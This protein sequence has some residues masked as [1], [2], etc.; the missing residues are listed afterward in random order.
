M[1]AFKVR[2]TRLQ[3]S[4]TL[5]KLFWTPPLPKA[6]PTKQFWMLPPLKPPLTLQFLTQPSPQP[7]NCSTELELE[8]TPLS[9]LEP[10]VRS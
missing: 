1:L 3:L 10:L 5:T 4:P 9:Q 2:P 6:Q 7:A 8:L